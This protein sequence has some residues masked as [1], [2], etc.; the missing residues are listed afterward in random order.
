LSERICELEEIV[1]QQHGKIETL[2]AKLDNM[3][4]LYS[5]ELSRPNKRLRLGVGPL[6][7]AS[8]T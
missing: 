5:R 6:S 3:D 7:V 8:G 4:R 2:R 1:L